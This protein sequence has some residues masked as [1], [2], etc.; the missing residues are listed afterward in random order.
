MSSTATEPEREAAERPDESAAAAETPLPDFYPSLPLE[1]GPGPEIRGTVV[2][3]SGEPLP[4]L[5]VRTTTWKPEGRGCF[6]PTCRLGWSE[7][8][9]GDAFAFHVDAE[10]LRL[11]PERK[12]RFLFSISAPGHQD[13]FVTLDAAQWSDLERGCDLAGLEFRLEL[14]RQE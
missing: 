7:I 2:S 13:L 9:P 12:G 3:A 8:R 11:M 5:S 10:M 1:F 14:L 6:R 4:W